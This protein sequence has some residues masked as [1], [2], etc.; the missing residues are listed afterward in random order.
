MEISYSLRLA[1]NIN[2]FIHPHVHLRLDR[3]YIKHIFEFYFHF[4]LELFVG[5]KLEIKC[6]I[7]TKKILIVL[8]ILRR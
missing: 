3:R 6:D 1:K 4:Q 8:L 7:L 5:I 2:N